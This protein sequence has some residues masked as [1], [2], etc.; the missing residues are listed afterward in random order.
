M[1]MFTIGLYYMI[2]IC[3][4]T[5]WIGELFENVDVQN[6]IDLLKKLLF[7]ICCNSSSFFVR[8]WL[9][10]RKGMWPV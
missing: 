10:D 4:V 7:V 5:S 3:F 8:C 9:G 1:K 2:V 6:V